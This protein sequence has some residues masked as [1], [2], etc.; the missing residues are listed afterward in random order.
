MRIKTPPEEVV[1]PNITPMIDM[2]FLLLIFFL[3]AT[4][5]ADVE[6]DVRVKPPSSRNARPVSAIPEEIVVNVSRDGKLLIGGKENAIP[7]ID[8]LFGTAV[9]GNP[10]QAVVIRGD[11][12]SV[13]QYAVDVLDL[14]EKHGIERTYLTTSVAGP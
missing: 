5:F 2:V 13:L 4:K 6:R 10:H 11:K 7:E 9:A 14:C 12:N 8:R 3:L 1:E